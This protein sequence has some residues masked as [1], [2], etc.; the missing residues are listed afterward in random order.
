MRISGRS[1]AIAA[2][3]IVAGTF[4]ATSSFDAYAQ[5]Q[6]PAAA[7]APLPLGSPLIGQPGTPEAKKLAPVAP[8]PI[9]AAADKLPVDKLKVPAGY[10][11]EVWASGIGNARSL[12]LGDK[13]TVFV[14]SRLLDKVSAV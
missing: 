8:P 9:P 5:Q 10:K 13:G 7:P 2:A 14:G 3:A 4:A 6:A 11:I 1:A 12:T